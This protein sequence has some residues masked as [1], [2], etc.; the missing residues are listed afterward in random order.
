MGQ[1]HQIDYTTFDR[2]WAT[3]SSRFILLYPLSKQTVVQTAMAAAGWDKA[4]A[5]QADLAKLQ[6]RLTL[7]QPS[8]D[9]CSHFWQGHGALAVAWDYLEMGQPSAART[10][11][12][13]ATTQG[14]N[15][16]VIDWIAEAITNGLG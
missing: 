8:N 5:Y 2:I 1:G 14:A 3:N 7:R 16:V 15:Q 10:A 12:A 11:L 4:T 13:D 9:G 6:R